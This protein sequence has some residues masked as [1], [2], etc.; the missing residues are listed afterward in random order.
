VTKSDVVVVTEPPPTASFTADVRSG[1]AALVVSFTDLSSGQISSW[2][3]SFG[4]GTNSSEPSPIHT[5]REPGFYSVTLTVT[6]S[7]GSNTLTETDFIQVTEPIFAWEAGELTIDD[8]W[9]WVDFAQTYSDPVVIAKPLSEK[10]GADQ[11]PA[12]V[13][14]DGIDNAGFWIRIQEWDY[15]DGSHTPEA[16]SYLVMESGSHQLPDGTQVEAG[17][18]E[19]QNTGTELS[20]TDAFAAVDFSQPFSAAPVVLTSVGSFVETDAVTTRVRNVTEGGFEVGMSEQEANAPVHAAEEIYFIAWAASAGNLDGLRYEVGLS[21]VA[22]GQKPYSI[23]FGNGFLA[24]P[25]S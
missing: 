10:R 18:L 15:L 5:Y 12:V 9:Q 11:D 3:W 19:V 21:D 22:V 13:R 14:L 24:P 7:G 23:S 4:D 17:H 6:G 1:P 16:V 8:V 2:H 25:C 20:A